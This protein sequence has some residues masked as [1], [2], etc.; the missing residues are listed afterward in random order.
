MNRQPSR[1]LRSRVR[2]RVRIERAGAFLVGGTILLGLAALNTGNNL[3]YLLLGS[4]FGTLVLSGWLSELTLRGLTVRRAVPRAVT[5]GATARI[6]YTVRNG[7][8]RTASHGIVVREAGSGTAREGGSGDAMGDGAAMGFGGSYVKT[9]EPGGAERVRALLDTTRRGVYPLHSVALATSYP[10]G[11]FTK[12]RH[13]PLAGSLVVWPR[14][15]RPVRRPLPGGERGMRVHAGAAAAHGIERGDYRGMREYRVGDDPRDIHWRTTARRG[16][17]ILR[18][19]DRSVSEEYWIVLD[20]VAADRDAGEAAIE[21]AASLVAAAAAR[22]DRFGLA[23]G[24]ARIPPGTAPGRAEAA[25]D[26][27]AAVKLTANGGAPAAP[28]AARSCVLV[29]ARSDHTVGWGD[30]YVVTAPS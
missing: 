28:A 24:G 23:A 15:D 7:R 12:E 20:T 10:F 8:R 30:T 2:R 26:L 5:A 6:E 4:L 1:P 22:G 14:T 13:L 25:L 17:P 9:L 16:E 27:L 29:T 18:E 11:L 3:L 19:Y 21:V